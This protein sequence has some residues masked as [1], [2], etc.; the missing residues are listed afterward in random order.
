MKSSTCIMS[1][2]ITSIWAKSS[3]KAIISGRL[4]KAGIDRSYSFNKVEL[5][6]IQLISLIIVGRRYSNIYE[7]SS[8]ALSCNCR[9]CLMTAL[10]VELALYLAFASLVFIIRIFKSD[11]YVSQAGLLI[12]IRTLSFPHTKFLKMSRIITLLWWFSVGIFKSLTRG[13]IKTG[14]SKHTAISFKNRFEAKKFKFGKSNAKLMY[15]SFSFFSI[16]AIVRLM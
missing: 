15:F 11:I 3:K 4:I 14:D 7:N 12:A 1:G 8:I 9:V 16:K 10:R 13:A 5:A 2:L 6:P